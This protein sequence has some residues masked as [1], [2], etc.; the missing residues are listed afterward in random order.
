[1]F[2]FLPSSTRALVTAATSALL[3]STT[4][5]TTSKL[6]ASV[7]PSRSLFSCS[8]ATVQAT[9]TRIVRMSSTNS[10]DTSQEDATTATTTTNVAGNLELVRSKIKGAC[11]RSNR[12]VDD[13]R[14]VAVSKVQP[15]QKLVDAYAAGQRYFGE[16]YVQELL[17]KKP[18]LSDDINWHFIGALQS[19]KAAGLVGAFCGSSD[20]GDKNDITRLTI[21]TVSSVKLAN[22]LNKAVEDKCSAAE[23]NKLKVMVQINTSGE[24]TKSG[25]NGNNEKVLELCRHIATQCPHLKLQG[26][27]TI[28][29]PG[30][31]SCFD[32]LVAC[33]NYVSEQLGLP[34]AKLELSMGMSGDYEAAIEKG[35]TNV[36]VGSTIFGARQYPPS[37]K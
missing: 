1:M 11:E 35:S 10:A 13:V 15:L 7:F 30:D 18:Q 26:L 36:R 22:K 3:A 23:G 20:D 32:K 4:T 5:R 19:N 34:Q 9:S 31:M 16:N 2:L 25:V 12:S 33:R 28:G 6:G 29:A 24:D 17:E 8:S 21:E 37:K 27:M 14:L